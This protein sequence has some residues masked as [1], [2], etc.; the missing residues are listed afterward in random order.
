MGP[1][2][3]NFL[4]Q[5]DVPFRGREQGGKL[6]KEVPVQANMLLARDRSPRDPPEEVAR[7]NSGI[8]LARRRREVAAVEEIPA[9]YPEIQ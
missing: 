9:E 2:R 5:G 1:A 8:F 7:R 3:R 6:V 4:Q